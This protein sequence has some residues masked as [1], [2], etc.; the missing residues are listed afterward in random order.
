MGSSSILGTSDSSE[1]DDGGRPDGRPRSQFGA[2]RQAEYRGNETTER[3]RTRYETRGKTLKY[4]VDFPKYDGDRLKYIEWSNKWLACTRAALS[5]RGAFTYTD[6]TDNELDE[7]EGLLIT[8][9]EDRALEMAN[10]EQREFGSGFLEIMAKL[11]KDWNRDASATREKAKTMFKKW[12][13]VSTS[14]T[15]EQQVVDSED[16]LR[17]AFGKSKTMGYVPKFKKIV[18][19]VVKSWN[20][21]YDTALAMEMEQMKLR[22]DFKPIDFDQIFS[23]IIPIARTFDGKNKVPRTAPLEGDIDPVFMVGE[24]KSG[25]VQCFKCKGYY[26][27]EDRHRRANCTA[28]ETVTEAI[29]RRAARQGSGGDGAA[30][31]QAAP[32]QGGRVKYKCDTCAHNHKTANCHRFKDG[33]RVM[34]HLGNPVAPKAGAATTGQFEKAMVAYGKAMKAAA[35][36]GVETTEATEAALAVLPQEARLGAASLF[37]ALQ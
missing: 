23:T 7:L 31:D 12:R 14:D 18:E 37:K 20:V 2:R 34:D 29:K 35:E 30:P 17:A 4:K 13:W 24:Y 25:H 21:E 27:P 1:T 28:S 9:L 10:E 32:G 19:L 36:A 22:T 5:L 3:D 16:S 8:K 33:V 11:H 6:L 15:F 26:P